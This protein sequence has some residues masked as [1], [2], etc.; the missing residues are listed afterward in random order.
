[1]DAKTYRVDGMTCGGCVASLT[2]ALQNALPG[3]Q[4]EVTLDGGLVRVHGTH[5][6]AKVQQPVSAAGFTLVGPA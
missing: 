6:V 4:I 1:V 3:L 2:R 5:D